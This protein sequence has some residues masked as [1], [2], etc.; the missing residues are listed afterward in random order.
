MRRNTLVV[1]VGE[2]I[3][4]IQNPNGGAYIGYR[5]EKRVRA[6]ER[7]EKADEVVTYNGN[8]YDIQELN[9]LSRELRRCK[10]LMNG[11]HTDMS[12]ICWPGILGSSL[13]DTFR[14]HSL[15]PRIFPD[16]YEGSNRRDVYMTMALWKWW[17][18]E[19][20]H[21]CP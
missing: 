11:L 14:E 16:T 3:I 21:P 20:G 10:F 13:A 1:D 9:R 15:A 7:L 6:L 17:M 12:E 18:E 8:R 5:S 19:Q 4:G 2:T